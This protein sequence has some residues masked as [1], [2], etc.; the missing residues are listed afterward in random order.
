[1]RTIIADR[2]SMIRTTRNNHVFDTSVH[3]TDPERKYLSADAEAWFATME[4]L[5]YYDTLTG[6]IEELQYL[7]A[8]IDQHDTQKA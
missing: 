8:W 5:H 4:D 6:H 3:A 2:L 1:M 7:T